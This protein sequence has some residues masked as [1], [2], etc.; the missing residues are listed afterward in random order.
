MIY[1][2][3]NIHD[4]HIRLSIFSIIL[5]SYPRDRL[6]LRLMCYRHIDSTLYEK[7]FCLVVA[8]E[9]TKL[10]KMIRGY[11]RQY[12]NMWLHD[13]KKELHLTWMI[14]T[15]FEDQIPWI[16]SNI[17]DTCAYKNPY[18]EKWIFSSCL[19]TDDSQWESIFTVIVI[20]RE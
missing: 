2:L 14:D 20:W 17:C 13:R 6:S 15:I 12:S 10:L 3:H 19:C 11:R 16:W 9:C 4:T 1:H 8:T 18:P 5:N 7:Q